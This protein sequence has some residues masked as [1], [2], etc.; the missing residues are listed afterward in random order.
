M[1][2]F[3]AV[4]FAE[5]D[6]ALRTILGAGKLFTPDQLHGDFSTLEAAAQA[7]AWPRLSV[8]RGKFVFLYLVPGLDF[9]RF[10][11]YLDGRPSLQGRAAFVQGLPGMTHTAFVLVDNAAVKPERIPAL[12]RQGYL[13]RTR[14]DIDT[15]EA[16]RNDP[17]RR[18][19]ALASGAQIISTDYLTTPNVHGNAYHVAPFKDGWRCNPVNARCNATENSR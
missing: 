15:D 18:D 9:A 2:P 12:V 6:D 13:V 5:V 8:T 7:G 10:A 19:K 1:P 16:R 14:A 3:D 11:P 17:S 4:A